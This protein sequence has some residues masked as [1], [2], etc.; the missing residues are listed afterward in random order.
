MLLKVPVVFFSISKGERGL[1]LLGLAIRWL[2]NHPQSVAIQDINEISLVLEPLDHSRELLHH[3]G[4]GWIRQ[5]PKYKVI[6]G[7]DAVRR[8]KL[9]F[10]NDCQSARQD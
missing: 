5:I 9:A 3:S 7:S 10:G 6:S 4:S 1:S 2:R 8:D